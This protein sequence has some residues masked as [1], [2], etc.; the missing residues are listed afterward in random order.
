M[1]GMEKSCAWRKYDSIRKIVVFTTRKLKGQ[2]IV[3]K[4]A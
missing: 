3:G 1:I 2:K 4:T